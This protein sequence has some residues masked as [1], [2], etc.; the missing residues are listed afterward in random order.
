MRNGWIGK[1]LLAVGIL[2]GAL[3]FTGCTVTRAL[4]EK[5]RDLEFTVTPQQEEPQE[6]KDIIFQKGTSPFK[7]TYSDEENLY[8]VVGY[9]QQTGG[10]YSICVHELYLTENA[11]VIDTELLGPEKG[12]GDGMADTSPYIVVKT[13]NIDSPVVFQ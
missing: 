9:G 13:E 12:E 4:G 2:A 3:L 6:L 10:G 1:M 7:L 8:I 11:I 5:M